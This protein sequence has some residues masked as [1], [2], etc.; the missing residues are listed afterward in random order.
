[1]TLEVTGLDFPTPGN[2]ETPLEHPRPAIIICPGGGFEFLSQREADPVAVAF[3]R[4]GFA[5][6]ILRYSLLEL[7]EFPN[8]AVDVV[9]AIRWVRAHADELGVDPTKVAV[10]GFSAGG[11]VAALAGT[12]YDHP[13]VLEAERTECDDEAVLRQPARPDAIVP[14]YA[15]FSFD[16]VPDAPE[17]RW[18]DTIAAVTNETP[19]AFVW[20]T[21]ED[22]VV[23]ATQSLRFVNALA[24]HGVPF[25]YHHFTRGV[26][27]LATGDCLANFDRPELPENV[28]FWVEL[29]ANWLRATL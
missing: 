28:H 25:E 9:R 20:T 10:M 18:V 8:P 2:F 7:A 5:T 14:A 29:C 26:H 1:M 27:G 12:M 11:N 16:W 3:Q 15:V 19:P 21:G 23:P 6:F 4:F 13:E 24:E 22:A 17:L